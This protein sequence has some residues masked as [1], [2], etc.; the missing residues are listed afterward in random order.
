MESR[1]ILYF[2]KPGP[3]NTPA[4]ARCVGQRCA[5][6]GIRYVVAASTTGYTA[7]VLWESL[8]P[9]DVRLVAVTHHAGF[10]G[11]DDNRMSAEEREALERLGIRVY[12]SSHALSGVE[13]SLTNKL[14]GV[15]RVEV[16]AHTL[17]RFGGDGL[18]VAVEVAIMAAD[19]GLVPTAEEVIAVGGTGRGADTA[20][21]LRAAHQNTFFDLEV[22][23]ILCKPRQRPPA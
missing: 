3:A 16:I 6:L 10:H 8:E 23:E 21:V 15:S 1:S 2:E 12:T 13:R 11:G 18:K 17:R 22:R 19:G 5:E 9:L 7:R 14:G 4:V 20:V